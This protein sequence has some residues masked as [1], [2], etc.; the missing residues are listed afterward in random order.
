VIELVA[1]G[2]LPP[3]GIGP[4]ASIFGWISPSFEAQLDG[5]ARVG[6]LTSARGTLGYS[7]VQLGAGATWIGLQPSKG[8][9]F[10]VDLRIDAL[11]TDLV[12]SREGVTQSRWVPDARLEVEGTWFFL[13]NMGAVLVTGVEATVGTTDV[14]VGTDIVATVHPFRAIGAL[15]VRVRF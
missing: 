1:L 15:G 3:E 2:A 4:S 13:P 12:V 11:A 9:P 8:R 10:A 5:G 14:A 7:S 6:Q